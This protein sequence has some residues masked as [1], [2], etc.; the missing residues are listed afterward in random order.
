MISSHLQD[1]STPIWQKACIQ[2][3]LSY[4]STSHW[5]AHKLK[6]FNLKMNKLRGKCTLVNLH[7]YPME[8]AE[9]CKLSTF[10]E[11][12]WKMG[13]F[14]GYRYIETFTHTSA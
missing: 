3:T 1:A 13:L 12:D 2:L 4:L 10:K 8:I 14:I 5:M 9:V 7:E 6:L 11:N